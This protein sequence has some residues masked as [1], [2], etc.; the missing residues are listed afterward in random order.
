MKY[1]SQF[2]KKIEAGEFIITAELLPQA[3]TTTQEIKALT[4]L[5]KKSI[6]AVNVADNPH[7]PI[8]SSLAGSLT[9]KQADLEP[10]YQIVTRD[11]NRIAIQSDLLGAAA[12]GIRN[13]LCLSGHHQALTRSYQSANVYDIDS[14]QLIVTLKKM[15]DE[16]L[17]LN[18]TEIKGDFPVLIGA[19]ASPDMKPIELNIMRLSKKVE[20]GADFIQ[21]QAVFDIKTFEKWL[22]Q[23]RSEKLTAKTAIMAGVM[24]LDSAEEAEVLRDKYTD[25]SIPDSVVNRLKEAGNE[26]AQKKEGLAICV[27]TIKMIKE[28]DGVRGIHILSGGKENMVPEI[29]AQSEL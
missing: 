14:I 13:V 10:V 4:A 27:E 25:L 8:M 17:L 16:S 29:I 28:M 22:D 23:A 2:A 9:L 19:A 26:A 20:A 11:R 3:S 21:T 6:T 15:R 18:G 24:P 1:D 7:G 5:F 12:L